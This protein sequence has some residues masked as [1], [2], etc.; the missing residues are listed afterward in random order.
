ML[1]THRHARAGQAGAMARRGERARHI[2]G[3]RSVQ[4]GR[5][6]AFGNQRQT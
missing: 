4:R 6:T 2:G 3:N 1:T 5:A